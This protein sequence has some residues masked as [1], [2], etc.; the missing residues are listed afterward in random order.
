[1][2]VNMKL[3]SIDINLTQEELKYIQKCICNDLNLY[4]EVLEVAPALIELI[5]YKLDQL[6]EY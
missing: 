3:K 5:K 4:S 6:N 1:M 2:N